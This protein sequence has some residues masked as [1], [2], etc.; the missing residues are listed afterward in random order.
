MTTK[1]SSKAETVEKTVGESADSRMDRLEQMLADQAATQGNLQTA[2]ARSDA[3]NEALRLRIEEM[4]QE[5]QLRE[6][7]GESTTPSV[8]MVS[9]AYV[10][11]NPLRIIADLPPSEEYPMGQKLAWKAPSWR[12]ESRGWKG[13]VPVLKEETGEGGI[14]LKM[15]I[16]DPPV[17]LMG[18]D[19][20][21]GYI[22]RMGLILCRIDTRIWNAERGH[23]VERD[24]KH[25]GVNQQENELHLPRR[26][27]SLVGPG[28]QREENPKFGAPAHFDDDEHHRHAPLE[29]PKYTED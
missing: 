24:E 19:S 18:E 28:M 29:S 25:R 8:D 3:E 5:R 27:V 4:T 1:T 9:D 7:T 11:Q 14:D 6:A 13:W 2:L 15:H 22:H 20:V 10:D 16:P 17:R 12:N 26:G 21:D 23:V